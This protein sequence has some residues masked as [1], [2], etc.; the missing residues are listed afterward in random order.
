MSPDN[1]DTDD[2]TDE[3]GVVTLDLSEGPS[4]DWLKRGRQRTDITSEE[5][6]EEARERARQAPRRYK[7]GDIVDSPDGIGVVTDIVIED[8]ETDAEGFD[9]IEASNHSP[10]YVIVT[11]DTSGRGLSV[12]KPSDLEKD[13]IET[14]GDL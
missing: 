6:M 11:E 5:D 8:R 10:A 13:D 7:E 12:F 4:I 2:E 1:T 14:D 9:D 3:E